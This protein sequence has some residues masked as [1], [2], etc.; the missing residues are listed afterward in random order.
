MRIV[1]KLVPTKLRMLLKKPRKL[2][3]SVTILSESYGH[4]MSI[5]QNRCIDRH[6]NPIPWYTYPAIEYL[7]SLDFTTARVLEYGSG[8][9]SLWWA[10]LADSVLAVEHDAGWYNQVQQH[11]VP[12]LTIKLAQSVDDYVTAGAGS[13]EPFQVV[14][15]DGIHRH[16][17]AQQLKQI[18][19]NECLIVLDNSDWH[20][21]TAKLLRE[22]LDLLQVDFHGF[23]PINPYTSTTSIFFTRNFKVTPSQ[24]RLPI[25]SAGALQQLAA[26]QQ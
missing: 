21:Q 12:N 23:G 3:R 15:I 17:C 2:L 24:G 8:A 18:I 16:R 9:S 22:D 13:G 26:D 10:A 7:Q 5:N 4:R 14:I 20:P 6:G 11:Q 25:Y 19:A 1:S